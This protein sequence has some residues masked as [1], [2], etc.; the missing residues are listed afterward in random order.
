V[1]VGVPTTAGTATARP[2]TRTGAA[3]TATRAPRTAAPTLRVEKGLLREGHT[4]VGACDEVGRGALGGPVTVGIVLVDASVQRPL[5]GVRDSKLLTPQARV[6]LVP[7]IRRWVAG[8]AVGHAS[9]EEIDEHGII[10][11]LRMAGTRALVALPAQPDVVLLDGNHDWL[12]RPRRPTLFD[13]SPLAELPPPVVRTMIKADLRCSSVAAASVLAKTERDAIMVRLAASHPGYGWE[14]NKGYSTAGHTDALRRLGPCVHHRQSWRLPELVDPEC[15]GLF[16]V[17]AV[18]VPVPPGD[19]PGAPQGRS[20]AQEWDG[21]GPDGE[22]VL[23]SLEERDLDDLDG[24]DDSYGLEDLDVLG[25]RGDAADP[26]R[27]RLRERA[28]G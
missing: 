22:P 16:E 9:A 1:T 20:A 23:E 28:A 2:T 18:P 25:G 26:G 14:I 6:A 21:D 5:A 7:R 27:E 4:L 10:A 12:S 19:A 15:D 11:A 3:R 13:D 24:L 17:P 8:H